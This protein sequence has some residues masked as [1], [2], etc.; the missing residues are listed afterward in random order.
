MS[1]S[2]CDVSNRILDTPKFNWADILWYFRKQ[3]KPLPD[4][5]QR[6]AEKELELEKEWWWFRGDHESR[7]RLN[8]RKRHAEK[9]RL[10]REIKFW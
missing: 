9:S 2:F 4:A 7:T 10:R 5:K 8:R 6:T 3:H 1:R